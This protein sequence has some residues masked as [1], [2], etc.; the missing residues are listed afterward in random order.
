MLYADH[1]AEAPLHCDKVFQRRYRMSRKLFLK[2]VNSIREFNS[3]F[4]CKKDCTDTL[5]FTSLQKC[6]TAMRMLA[7]GAPGDSL[8]DYGRMAESTS[9]ECFYKFC[10]AVSS[11]WT[12]ILENT[13][14]GRHC[15]DPSTE[16]S[17]RISWDAWKHRLH[18]PGMKKLSICLAGDVQRRQRRLQC[19]T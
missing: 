9:I 8:D 7:Y 10:R 2:I 3:Y 13:Q 17:K 5:G 6:T 18:A 12:A 11:V 15:S 4:K 19:G 16:C 1:F 14:C